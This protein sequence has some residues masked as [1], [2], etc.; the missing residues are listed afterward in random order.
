MR[1]RATHK[2]NTG[3]EQVMME[4]FEQAD[5]VHALEAV[6]FTS[7]VPMTEAAL[8]GVFERVWAQEPVERQEE[9]SATFAHALVAL[10]ERWAQQGET[11]GFT[12]VEVAEGYAF[13]THP[14]YASVLRAMRE[15]KPL[16][17]SRAALETLAIVAYRQPVTKPD[18]DFI[19]GVDC[20]GS[21]KQLLERDLVKIV[22]K[23]EEAGRPLL[24]GTTREFLSFF[25][26]VQL[27]QLPS[28][29]EYHEL[30]EA[31]QEELHAMEG[32]AGLHAL[33]ETAKSL[34]L[35]EE[36]AVAD[37]EEAVSSLKSTESHT[38][39]ALAAQGISLVQSEEEAP[40][41]AS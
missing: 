23:K 28:L 3:G 21:L 19:R 7:G 12:L 32:I 33:T 5:M 16:R 34:R 31:S 11:C 39:E 10:K 29:R 27:T 25:N 17:L 20:G 40:A 26:L 9:L 30:N 8:L 6:L 41:A 37:L 1:C 4:R 24:Y 14:R 38:R 13:R 2:T 15:E 35:E 18:M 36:P 22:G